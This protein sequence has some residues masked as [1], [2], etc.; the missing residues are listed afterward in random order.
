MIDMQPKTETSRD[1]V[2]G[3]PCPHFCKNM[4]LDHLLQKLH[5]SRTPRLAGHPVLQHIIYH[6]TFKNVFILYCPQAY[7]QKGVHSFRY[8]LQP[9]R[10]P[11]AHAYIQAKCIMHEQT[12]KEFTLQ[13]KYL[14]ECTPFVYVSLCVS[15]DTDFL[16]FS[17]EN[18]WRK[19]K[20]FLMWPSFFTLW[21]L[22]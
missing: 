6:V 20:L 21:R 2:R 14:N 8:F 15:F 18:R 10:T 17:Q 4:L 7:I 11:Y 19:E 22:M 1:G 9:M 5:W 3:G 12:T 16:H 13:G